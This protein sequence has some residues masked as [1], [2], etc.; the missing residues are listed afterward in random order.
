MKIHTK[1]WKRKKILYF[2]QS[3][4]SWW[5][6]SR[7]R[8]WSCPWFWICRMQQDQQQRLWSQSFKQVQAKYICCWLFLC[9][10]VCLQSSFC[11]CQVGNWPRRFNGK[12]SERT[13]TE[14]HS[15]VCLRHK[16]DFRINPGLKTLFLTAAE[17]C[18]TYADCICVQ[19]WQPVWATCSRPTFLQ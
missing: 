8:A 5:S 12:V 11:W 4:F 3:G 15:G 1:H 17:A 6:E 16:Q 2:F 10:F 9:L 14:K 13:T 18:E 19:Q 7:S